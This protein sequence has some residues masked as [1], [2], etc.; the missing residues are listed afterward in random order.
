MRKNFLNI[1][2]LA[3]I[4]IAIVGCKNKTEETASVNTETAIVAIQDAGVYAVNI[5]ES[6]IEWKG[7]KPTG[8]H[9]GTINIASGN[10]TMG[11]N[12]INGGTFVFDMTSIKDSEG[13]ARLEGHLKSA[14]FFEVE[15]YPTATF[16]I[17]GLEENDGQSVLTGNLTLKSTTNEVAFPVTVASENGAVT[18]SSD[19]FTIDRSK[20]NVRYGSKS[21][22][23]DLQDKFI[24][25]EIELKISVKANKS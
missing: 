11:D 14:D 20:W 23:D 15:T 6:T 3:I 10:F 21:F 22:F 8:S 18:V 25:D 13:N 17:I 12:G 1:F 2:T 4:G 7:F 19:V 9:L 24:N 5:D 16:E